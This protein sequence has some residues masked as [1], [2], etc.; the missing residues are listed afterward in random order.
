MGWDLSVNFA[1]RRNM[2][3]AHLE[4]FCGILR[5]IFE[6]TA[7]LDIEVVVVD[8]HVGEDHQVLCDLR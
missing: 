7:V 4:V 3:Y 8:V 5:L 6:H 1:L 2:V